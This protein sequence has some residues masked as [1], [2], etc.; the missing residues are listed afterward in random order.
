MA[1]STQFSRWWRVPFPGIPP[2]ILI[3]YRDL[4]QS[5]IKENKL[6]PVSKM[7]SAITR[8]MLNPQPLPPKQATR[9][10]AASLPL[11]DTVDWWWKYGGIRIPHIHYGE[12][13]Y[14]LDEKQWQV[15]TSTVMRDVTKKLTGA[16]NISFDQFVNVANAANEVV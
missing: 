4:I 8:I 16:K 14:A 15:F 12:D 13:V 1:Q 11:N 6:T 2:E 3:N 10:T 5:I 7:D 9:S